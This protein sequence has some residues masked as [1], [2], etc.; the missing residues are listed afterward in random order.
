MRTALIIC[1]YKRPSS[2][3]N[4]LQSIEVQSLCPDEVLVI[5]GSN[6]LATERLIKSINHSYPLSYYRVSDEMRGLTRQRNYGIAKMNGLAEIVFFLD[7]D[8]ILEPNYFAEVLK[9]YKKFPD[10]LGVGGIDLEENRYTP[11]KVGRIYHP[12]WFYELDGWVVSEPARYRL[13]K[14]LGLMPDS[15]PGII[16]P[17]SNG[18]SSFPPNGRTYPVEHFMGGIASFRKS[19]FSEI[20]FSTYFEGYGLYEDFDFTVRASRLGKLYVNTNAR[21]RHLHE[22]AGRPNPFRYG[23][24]VVRNGWYVWRVRFP[25]P[26]FQ[27]RVRWHLVIWLMI[28]SKFFNVL[29]GPGRRGALLETIGRVVSWVVLCFDKPLRTP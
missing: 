12:F 28:L 17:Y 9:T 1:T 26:T 10:A 4:L 13:R 22:A 25:S 21:V 16:P 18:R 24:M 7:D 19:V 20:Q 6:D 29:R 14:I 15:R 23:W 11:K 2:L 3:Q 27:A 5:D 8:L